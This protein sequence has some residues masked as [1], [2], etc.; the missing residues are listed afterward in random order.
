MA[1][2]GLR[3]GEIPDLSLINTMVDVI[4]FH[5][6]A[7]VVLN[8]NSLSTNSGNNTLNT[9]SFYQQ[10]GYLTLISVWLTDSV[11]PPSS[12]ERPS[13]SASVDRADSSVT[14]TVGTGATDSVEI[15]ILDRF[16]NPQAYYLHFLKTSYSTSH[17]GDVWITFHGRNSSE[18]DFEC[19][20]VQF[21]A[22]Q[23]EA[24]VTEVDRITEGVK[25]D[26]LWWN[27]LQPF[28]NSTDKISYSAG[29]FNSANE[30]LGYSDLFRELN[31]EYDFRSGVFDAYSKSTSSNKLCYMGK[32][33]PI[34]TDFK[35]ANYS[36]TSYAK[37]DNF[38]IT[39]SRERVAI[40]MGGQ[41][42]GDYFKMYGLDIMSLGAGVTG[43]IVR[44]LYALQHFNFITRRFLT[45][46]RVSGSALSAH[47][48]Y[49][50]KTCISRFLSVCF[51][52]KSINL[53][54]PLSDLRA[55]TADY[56]KF[57][58]I[59]IEENPAYKFTVGT[60]IDMFFYLEI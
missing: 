32:F 17:T 5:K 49:S 40:A 6:R 42:E 37:G 13:I 1:N 26:Y 31:N 48:L 30:G 33:D 44:M 29:C 45:N 2:Y 39:D 59:G 35:K 15:E 23:H 57:A 16:G 14:Y 20:M 43:Q 51:D 19:D 10:R 47:D 36:A 12:T 3:G 54:Y 24:T 56:K 4:N 11:T 7:N 21:M 27:S 46:T 50:M 53:V 25:S 34:I 18:K 9:F 55:S 38:T 28:L 22:V 8:T 52:G 41:S 58:R 60:D